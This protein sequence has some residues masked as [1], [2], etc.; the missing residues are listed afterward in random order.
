[1]QPWLGI[2]RRER[3]A[4]KDM[5]RRLLA[6]QDRGRIQIAI[7]DARKDRAVGQ[8][9]PLD[10]DHPAVRIDHGHRVVG[11]AH[12]AGAAGM[13]G[14]LGML[15]DDS[16]ELVIALR[17]SA[18]LD[19]LATVGRKGLLRENLARQTDAGAKILPIL[20]MGHVVEDNPGRGVGITAV[21]ADRAA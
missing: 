12:L 18:R 10:P 1:M 11:A 15:A 9:Q 13:V 6:D 20:V 19:F 21:Q 8:A 3:G 17:L 4:A 14:A 16:V 2:G 7:G 5:I